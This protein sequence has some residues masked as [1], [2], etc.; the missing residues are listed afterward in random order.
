[1]LLRFGKTPSGR[2]VRGHIS[3]AL[4]LNETPHKRSLVRKRGG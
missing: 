3:S 2:E 1:V 4:Q